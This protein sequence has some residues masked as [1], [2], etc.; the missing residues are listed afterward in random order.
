MT[1]PNQ[2]SEDKGAYEAIHKGHFLAPA[3]RVE[4]EKVKGW[5]RKNREIDH[6]AQVLSGSLK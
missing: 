6:P 4:E 1:K 2:K 5:I 3:P